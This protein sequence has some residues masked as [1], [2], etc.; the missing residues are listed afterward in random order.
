MIKNNIILWIFI[1]FFGSC[2][3]HETKKT[4][5]EDGELHEII[6]YQNGIIDGE[7][8]T[9]NEDGSKAV[10]EWKDGKRHGKTTIYYDKDIIN[11]VSTYKQ[12]LLKGKQWIYYEN[13]RLAELRNYRDNKLVGRQYVYYN[14][15]QNSIYQIKDYVNYHGKDTLCSYRIYNENMEIVS[16]TL[17]IDIL[18]EDSSFYQCEKSLVSARI[19]NDSLKNTRIILGDFDEEFYLKEA[20]K[21]DTIEL[22]SDSVKLNI[23]TR[24]KGSFY[25]RG[26]VNNYELLSRNGDTTE[27][28]HSFVYFEW[29]YKVE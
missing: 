1:V 26:L 25:L 9:Y 16:G 15:D 6:E 14:N 19:F 11:S 12:G 21:L 8:I 22:E 4:Y 13:G 5:Y 7:R 28:I 3:E 17:G 20:G 23:N 24:I 27:T 18:N 2:T 10:S 29:P